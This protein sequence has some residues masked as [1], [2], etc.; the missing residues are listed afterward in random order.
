M[1]P[2]ISA[3]P[4][5]RLGGI[6]RRLFSWQTLGAALLGIVLAR[7]VWVLFAPESPAMPPASWEASGDAGRLFG[8]ASVA[9]AP[10]FAPMGNI[11]LIGVFAHRTM[12]FAVMQVDEKQIGVAQGEEVKPGIRLAETYPDHVMLE[13][14]GV[15]QRVDLS[16]ASA[17]GGMQNAQPGG[18]Q[19]AQPRGMQNAQPGGMGAAGIAPAY[20]APVPGNTAPAGAPALHSGSAPHGSPAQIEALQKQLD[21]ADNMPPERREALKNKL[22]QIRGQ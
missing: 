3:R 15:R 18:M 10:A 16:G 8:T 2:A 21:A 14:A 20:A 11:K 5:G 4:S 13:Q 17:P 9:N 1:M 22:D 19:N 7:W 12:G 6:A